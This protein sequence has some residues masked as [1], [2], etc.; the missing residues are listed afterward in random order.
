M[1]VRLGTLKRIL[2]EVALSPSVFNQEPVK[3]VMDRPNVAKAIASLEQPFRNAVQQNLVLAAK[4]QY[5]PETRELDDGVW[6]HIKETSDRATEMMM[7]GVHKAVQ[8]A[9]A[10]ASKGAAAEPAAKKAVA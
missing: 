3:D 7:A 5:N 6:E 4:G 10:Q 1:K 2:R 8:Q 9:W